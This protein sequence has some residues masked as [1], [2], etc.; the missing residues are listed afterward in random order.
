LMIALASA[1]QRRRLP[2]LLP[3]GWECLL[4]FALVGVA[5]SFILVSRQMMLRY[6]LPTGFCGLILFLLAVH[7]PALRR[8]RWLQIGVV[9]AVGL[10]LGRHLN[11]DRTSHDQ[12]VEMQIDLQARIDE[13]IAASSRQDSLPPV[14]LYSFRAPEPSF[15]LRCN[16]SNDDLLRQIEQRY[17]DDGHYDAWTNQVRLPHGHAHWSFLVLEKQ[18]LARFPEPIGP[19]LGVV[20]EFYV[21]GAP[22]RAAFAPSKP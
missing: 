12:R 8:L 16:A 7:H 5:C 10:L 6:L 17:P 4:A 20:D 14:V 1:W 3:D 18:Y 11:S 19:I 9:C 13:V 15:A 2:A 22:E 21:I